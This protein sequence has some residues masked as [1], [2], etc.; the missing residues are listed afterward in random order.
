MKTAYPKETYSLQHANNLMLMQDARS[1]CRAV[2][3]YIQVALNRTDSY[4]LKSFFF[5]EAVSS[6]LPLNGFRAL[7]L[8]PVLGV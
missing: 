5:K 6:T 3:E 2:P 4:R 1:L 7:V 8:W